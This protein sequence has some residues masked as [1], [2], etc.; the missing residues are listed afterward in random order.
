[1]LQCLCF[2]IK[3][4]LIMIFVFKIIFSK[5]SLLV[6]STD[7]NTFI[8]LISTLKC[9]LSAVRIIADDFGHFRT[10]WLIF[11]H[12]VHMSFVHLFHFHVFEW[13]KL[14]LINYV[15]FVHYSLILLLSIYI[16][17]VATIVYHRFLCVNYLHFENLWLIKKIC[18]ARDFRV[19]YFINVHECIFI[20]YHLF[21][22]LWNQC[23]KSL[24]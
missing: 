13:H 17:V 22:F 20:Y 2:L 15:V 10:L 21:A 7:S 18:I 8:D 5:T 6:F 12:L 16:V 24:E 1:M 3:N 23:F 9:V 4:L 14:C 11:N 19:V